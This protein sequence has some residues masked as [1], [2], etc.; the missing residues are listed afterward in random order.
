MQSSISHPPEGYHK[1][2]ETLQFYEDQLRLVQSCTSGS[3]KISIKANETTWK[4]FQ[5]THERTRYIYTLYYTR[6][7]ISAD[8]YNW[9]LQHRYADKHLIAKWK[10]QGYEKLCCV[11]CIQSDETQF[12]TTCI[13]RVPRAILEQNSDRGVVSFKN[14]IH[15]GCSGC[16]ST[17]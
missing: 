4:I 3:S 7:A 13:C 17:D 11:R 15:C 12:G 8:L 5:I 9:L 6:K 2:E 14:C 1:I 16:A 10:K